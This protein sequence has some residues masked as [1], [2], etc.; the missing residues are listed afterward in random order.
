MLLPDEQTIQWLGLYVFVCAL[1]LAIVEH[2]RVRL[3]KW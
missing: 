1:A 3:T 2:N